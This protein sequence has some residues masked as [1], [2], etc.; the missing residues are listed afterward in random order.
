MTVYVSNHLITVRTV[1]GSGDALVRVQ[2]SLSR[3][4]SHGFADTLDSNFC[5]SY[6]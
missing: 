6:A 2:E 5:V 1:A 3:V 4:L